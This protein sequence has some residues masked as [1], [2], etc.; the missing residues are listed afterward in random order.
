V[1]AGD[2]TTSAQIGDASYS[3]YGP[4]TEFSVTVDASSTPEPATFSLLPVGAGILAA[5]KWRRLLVL[6]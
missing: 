5:A 2:P 6:S 1:Y 3:Y 4:S